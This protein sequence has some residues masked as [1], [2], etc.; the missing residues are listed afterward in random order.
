[1]N[2]RVVVRVLGFI[3]AAIGVAMIPSAILAWVEHSIDRYAFL[4]SASIPIAAGAFVLALTRGQKVDLRIR[5]GFAITTFSWLAAAIFGGLPYVIAGVCGP[6]DAFF[7]SLSG[8]TTTGATIFDHI[9]GLPNATLLWRSLTQWLGGM[10]IVVLSV[11]I[12]PMLGVGGMQLFRAEV[13][14]PTADRLS[15]RI[16]DTAKILWTVY[17]GLTV[18]QTV[19]LM[20][21]GMT[22]FDAICH[23]FTTLS[24]G[25]FSTRD[26][27]VGAFN[28][29][30]IDIVITV[31]MFISGANFSLHYWLLRGRW[32]HYWKNEEFRYYGLVAGGA[33][34]L[35]LV[36]ILIHTDIGFFYGLR[37]A[38]FQAVS[39][40][41][42][43]GYG[44]GDYLLWGFGAHMLIFTVM[45]CGACAGS[46]AGGVKVMRVVLLAKH[47][48]RVVKKTLHPH[49]VFNVRHSGKVVDDEVMMTVLGF[50]LL[51]FVLFLVAS[52]LVAHFG[53][54]FTTALGAVV[55]TLGNVGPG[56][57]EVGPALTYSNLP[58]ASK[59]VLSLCMLFGRLELFTVFVLLTPMFWR[60]VG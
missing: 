20:F 48:N 56:L 8:F 58:G 10:G 46:T 32:N 22:F 3:A 15:P 18:I 7:E 30:Y 12:L 29:A 39:I 26:R 14:G 60:R 55:S 31:F 38:L 17:V 37:L 27:S 53:A 23:T 50:F 33:T 11:A 41:T 9:E 57:G 19:L 40:I 47:A 52:T 45:F 43:T 13:P 16:Q 1:M 54:D 5:E 21:G 24:T 34:L 35:L 42:T 36:A 44:T 28:S 59:I 25:G 49:A 2:Y 51:Y 6:I 4:I